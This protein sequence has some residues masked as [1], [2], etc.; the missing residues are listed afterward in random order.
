MNQSTLRQ[1][2]NTAGQLLSDPANRVTA[3]YAANSEGLRTEATLDDASKFCL[4][5][6]LERSSE[7]DYNSTRWLDSFRD[8]RKTVAEVIGHPNSWI[9]VAWDETDDTGREAIV[10]KLLGYG[11]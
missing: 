11:K 1:I 7:C 9:A 10:Q 8:I 5:G 4:V 2:I 6:A 3:M